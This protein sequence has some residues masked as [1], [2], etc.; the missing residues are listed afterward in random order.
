MLIRCNPRCKLKDGSTTGSLDVDSNEVICDHC[1]DIVDG[2]SSFAKNMMKNNGDV[3]RKNKNKPFQF[4]CQTCNKITETV[5]DEDDNL[6]GVSCEDGGCAFSG[7]AAQT[8]HAMKSIG[9]Y[10]GKISYE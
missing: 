2:I 5:L 10:K 4:E 9:R 7:V 8:V 1:G 6:V 3:V